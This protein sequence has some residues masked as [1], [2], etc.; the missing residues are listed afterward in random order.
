[1]ALPLRLRKYFYPR[2]PRG[3]R[4]R[5]A[6]ILAY[7]AAFL[8]T[9]PARGA[10]RRGGQ[11]RPLG[12]ISTHAPREG[13]DDV[14]AGD[15]GGYIIS[16]HAP[17][18]GS[19]LGAVPVLFQLDISTHAPREGSDKGSPRLYRYRQIST[20]APREGSDEVNYLSLILAMQ[21]LPTLP[22]RGATTRFLT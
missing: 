11:L 13:S 9:L 12:D 3:E 1:M 5:E 17:R 10:T 15:L 2:S 18:E 22:A 14:E 6:L 19:D 21:F 16:T 4:P 20:H 8:P 7:K